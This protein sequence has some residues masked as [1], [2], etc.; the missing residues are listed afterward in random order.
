MKH[1]Y[2]YWAKRGVPSA[3]VNLLFGNLASAVVMKEQIGQIYNRIYKQFNDVPYVGVYK[4]RTPSLMLKDPDL[5][6]DILIKDFDSFSANDIDISKEDTLASKNPFC[7]WGDEWKKTRGMLN[8]CYTGAKVKGMFPLIQHVGESLVSYVRD[9]KSE[10]MEMKDLCSRF[11]IDVVANCAFG[12]EGQSFTNPDADFKKMGEKI[13]QPSVLTGLKF[14]F[15]FIAPAFSKFLKIKFI[16]DDVSNYFRQI[17]DSTLSYRN[18]NNVVREDFLKAMLELKQKYP[19]EFTNEDV[20]AHALGFFIDG[21]ETSSIT[22][23][24]ILYLLAK[25]KD[26]QTKLRQEI[27]MTLKQNNGELT[28]EIVQNMPY[29]DCVFQESFRVYPVV[30]FTGR[31]CTKRYDLPP[32]DKNSNK[33]VTIDPGMAIIIPIYGLANDELYFSNPSKFD[34]ERFNNENKQQIRKGTF[35]VFGEGPKSCLGQR[36]GIMQVKVG[37]VNVIKNFEVI[38]NGKTKEPIQIDPKSFLNTALGGLW[39]NFKEI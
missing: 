24:F 8:P 21:F 20:T 30:M 39:L 7:Q 16:S 12:L 38:V 32:I 4:M 36:F 17:I 5:I 2:S 18:K 25:N 37:I 10:T 1:V 29:L 28:Y 26:E 31:K 23:A 33:P 6:R 11:T 27:N 34:P 14:L 9:R 15:I 3:E 19:S 35:S 13:F 22:M